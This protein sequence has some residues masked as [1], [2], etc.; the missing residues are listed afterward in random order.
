MTTEPEWPVG[1]SRPVAGSMRKTWMALTPS[2]AAMRKRP[3]GLIAQCRELRP[4]PRRPLPL[5]AG[6]DSPLIVL[7]RSSVMCGDNEPTSTPPASTNSSAVGFK[8]AAVF[9]I[10]CLAGKSRDGRTVIRPPAAYP[11]KAG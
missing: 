5:G 8:P 7:L 3:V 6:R 1:V 9:L 4:I 11:A 2:A 10:F